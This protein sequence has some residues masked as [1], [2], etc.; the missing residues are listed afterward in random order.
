MK[1]LIYYFTGT[2]NSLAV[3]RRIAAG[4]GDAELVGIP[5]L[6]DIARIVPEAPGSG[7]SARCMDSP[8]LRSSLNSSGGSTLP[9]CATHSLSSP[10]RARREG[11][12]S[13]RD[14]RSAGQGRTSMPGSPSA[15]RR[16]TSLSQMCSPHQTARDS[17][18]GGRK[19]CRDHSLNCGR[20]TAFSHDFSPSAAV[21][22]ARYSDT[23]LRPLSPPACTR[24]ALLCR[25]QLYRLW[26]MRTGLSGGE[27]RSRGR[28][29]AVEAPL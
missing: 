24:S 2:G 3:A 29:P 10:P 25:R 1:T 5:S 14:A 17:R 26:D 19:A 12:S 28:P 8:S 16:T 6:R 11:R 20:R 13:P 15:C 18:A 9:P 7:S 27:Y 21:R 23:G 22:V 4:L